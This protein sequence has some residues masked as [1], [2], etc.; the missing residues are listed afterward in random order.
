MLICERHFFVNWHFIILRCIAQKSSV[1][2]T[3][4]G[5]KILQSVILLSAHYLEINAH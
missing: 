1:T 5:E 4:V 3:A 2:N